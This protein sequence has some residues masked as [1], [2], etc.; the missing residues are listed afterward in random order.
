LG[1][2]VSVNSSDYSELWGIP[3]AFFG[4]LSF[5]S[6]LLMVAFGER[7]KLM[8]QYQLLIVFGISLFGFLFSLYLTFLEFFVIKAICQW[9]VLSALCMTL[10]FSA[11]IAWIWQNQVTN[12]AL[13]RR[14]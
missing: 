5:L 10:I 3:I 13:R 14:N 7:S 1:D 12:N 9:C 2:C 11:S 4:I 6:I 8:K